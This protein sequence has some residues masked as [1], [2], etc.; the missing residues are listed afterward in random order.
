MHKGTLLFYINA[1]HEGGAER[2]ILQVAKH[3]AESGYKSVLVTSFVDENEYSV[4]DGVERI[5]LEEKQ[6]KQ[7]KIQRNL[8]RVIA[9]R[10]MLKKYNPDAILSFMAEPNL[11]AVLA[12]IGRKTKTII[13]VRNDPNREYAGRLGNFIGKH[14]LPMADGCV[15]QTEEAKAWFPMALQK[16]SQVIF[17]DVDPIFFETEYVGGND[18]VTLGRLCAQK[19]HKLLIDAFARISDKHKD[20]NL[21]IYGIGP[22]ESEIKQYISSRGMESRIVLKG[23]TSESSVVLSHAKCFVLSS[24]YE[25]MPNALLEALAIGVPSISTDCPCGGPRMLIQN[26]INGFLVPINDRD[27]LAE[28]LNYLLSNPNSATAFGRAAKEMSSCY[29]TEKVFNQWKKYVEHIINGPFDVEKISD[30]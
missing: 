7:N 2:V 15:F 14:I 12:N 4:P 13:S 22:L 18:I 29:S 11:R 6:V 16:K 10:K 8:R 30:R 1:I 25:G 27:A 26:G 3:F 17:N 5:S 28:K 19:N 24:D 9:L 21:L 20:T 23:L